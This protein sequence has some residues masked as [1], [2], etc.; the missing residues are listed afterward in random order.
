MVVRNPDG[1]PYILDGSFEQFDPNSPDHA[2][3]N[4]WDQESIRQGGSPILYYELIISPQT[5]DKQYL[6]SRGKIFNQFPIQL[7]CTYDPKYSQ[8]LLNPFGIDSPDEISIE[9]NAQDMLTKI[10][11]PPKIGSILKTPHLNEFWEIIQR[12][13]G[14]YKLWGVLRYTI[15]AKRFQESTTTGEGAIPKKDPLPDYKII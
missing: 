12:N 7:Y 10:G 8:N 2:L 11:H 15:I 14:E 1:T 6:E 4:L 9:F 13:T 5:I 3:F